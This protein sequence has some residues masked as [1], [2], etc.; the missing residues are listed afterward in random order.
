MKNLLSLILIISILSCEHSQTEE[1]K[2]IRTESTNNSNGANSELILGERI[3]GPAN[4]RDKPNGEILFEFFDNALVEISP[5]AENGWYKLLIYADINLQEF[6]LDTISKGRFI[7]VDRDTIG[8]V[9][10]SHSLSL[11]GGTDP[12]YGRFYGYTHEDN[13][14]PQT[15]IE[16]VF[17]KHL[18]EYGRDISVWKNFIKTFGFDTNAVNYHAF[19]TFYNYESTVEDPSPGFRIVLLFEKENLIGFIHSRD[20][21]IA[22]TIRYKLNWSFYVSFFDEYPKKKQLKFMDYMNEWIEGVD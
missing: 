18:S 22:K 19:Q 14:K 16:T 12:Y 2:G 13:I 21:K 10:K 17:K 15:V 1:K 3:D 7:I 4:I 6:E 9:K 5:K 8:R 11:V 20:F